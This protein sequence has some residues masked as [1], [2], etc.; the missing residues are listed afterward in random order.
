M[1]SL[2]FNLK[3]DESALVSKNAVSALTVFNNQLVVS[4]KAGIQVFGEDGNVK[5]LAYI[6]NDRVMSFCTIDSQL[7]AGTFNGDVYSWQDKENKPFS[8]PKWNGLKQ[9]YVNGIENH[10][11]FLWFS[12][13]EGLL[14]QY[15]PKTQGFAS[16]P[17]L[18]KQNSLKNITD[19]AFDNAGFLWVAS[20][21]GIH[22]LS[23][24]FQEDRYEYLKSVEFSFPVVKLISS[25]QG[26]YVF[27]TEN[28]VNKLSVGVL[29]EEFLDAKKNNIL[30]PEGLQSSEI[31]HITYQDGVL[32]ILADKLY[33]FKNFQWENYTLQNA[34]IENVNAMAIFNNKIILGTDQGLFSQALNL[35]Q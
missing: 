24:I 31:V 12:T 14:F 34:K 27:Y 23:D 30:L 19:I 28:G 13:L 10:K 3:S 9:Y 32:W 17:L 25:E 1:L 35:E 8:L 22:F 21:D 33:S 18:N 16:Y 20:L 11:G 15:N 5:D 29:K 4:G 26:V 6:K 7:W 2:L